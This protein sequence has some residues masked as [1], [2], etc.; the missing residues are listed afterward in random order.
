[1]HI[2][3]LDVNMINKNTKTDAVFKLKI[4]GKIS[5]GYFV[6][7][8]LSFFVQPQPHVN[9]PGVYHKKQLCG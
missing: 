2:P 7:I 4:G 1:M 3:Q 9:Y 8:I 6:V 5:A